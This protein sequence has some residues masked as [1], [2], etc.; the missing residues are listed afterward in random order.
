[1]VKSQ[2]RLAS[3]DILRGFDLFL[4]VALQPIL[5]RI[6]EVWENPIYH[7][8]LLQ[9]EHET[10]VGFRIW[11]VIMPLFLFMTGVTI[12]FSL[13]N[14]LAHERQSIYKQ[15]VRRFLL[16]WLLGMIMQGNLLAWEWSKLKLYSN[17]LQ[18]IATGYLFTALMY[19]HLSIRQMQV[20]SVGLL[21]LYAIPFIINP[22][23][24]L[25]HNFAM[26]V[27]HYV[28][29]SFMDGVKKNEDGTWIYAE[30]YHYTWIWSSL[31]FIVTVSLGCFAGKWIKDG[32][33][34]P[35]SV[36]KKLILVGVVCVIVS[37]LWSFQLP[38]IKKIWTSSMTLF[39]GGICLLLLALFYYIIDIKQQGKWLGWLKIFGMNSIV[40]YFIGLFIDFSSIVHSIT[41]GMEHKWVGYERLII[42]F[43]NVLLVVGI[44]LLM[45]RQRWFVKI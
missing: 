12:P 6:G 21:L 10:W 34:N 23:F 39:S 24:S 40:A 45:Y 42:T 22:D 7:S 41:Y 8:L 15:I 36:F 17:T 31:T 14:R 2:Q 4:L 9:F 19:M 38:I 29:G 26:Q 44:L 27:D 33:Q 16:L 25:H 20:I 5:I 32:R 35:M 30:W 1:M 3:L 13:D 43:G 18:A 37:L 11:D 28:L